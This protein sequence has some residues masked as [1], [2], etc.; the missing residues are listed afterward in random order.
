MK[1]IRAIVKKDGTVYEYPEYASEKILSEKAKRM[2]GDSGWIVFTDPKNG[3]FYDFSTP[4]VD[5]IKKFAKEVG[6]I[7]CKPLTAK[8]ITKSKPIKCKLH[9]HKYI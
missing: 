6:T 1:I 3:K 7:K 9:K 2:G 8:S 5:I 4:K